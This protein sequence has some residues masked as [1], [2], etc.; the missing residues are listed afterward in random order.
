MVPRL[1]VTTYSCPGCTR[2]PKYMVSG[3]S[4]PILVNGPVPRLQ[5]RMVAVVVERQVGAAGDAAG[6]VLQ[7]LEQIGLGFDE[8]CGGDQALGLG[9][10]VGKWL[11]VHPYETRTCSNSSQRS[12]VT[13]VRYLEQTGTFLT[14]RSRIVR[15]GLAAHRARGRAF[16]TSWPAT[17]HDRFGVSELARRLGLSKPTC[18]GIVT[19]LTDSGYLVRDAADKTYRLGPALITLGHTAQESLRVNP[20]ARDG[21]APAV[22]GSG[23]TA[24]LSAVIDDRI[25]LLDLVAPAGRRCR[26]CGSARA[27]RSPR[28]S[29]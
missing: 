1:P 2:V 9:D 24:A 10:R 6:Q 21:T 19:T 28:R 26:A 8:R 22:G 29:G 20:A 16:S 11:G 15:P 3:L 14:C 13:S 5:E 25:T 23:T 27:I 4:R 17:P 18:L 12:T 7:A